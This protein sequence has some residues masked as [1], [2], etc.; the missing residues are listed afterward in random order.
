MGVLFNALCVCVGVVVSSPDSISEEVS[1]Q[2]RR[3]S[4]VPL[5]P[6]GWSQEDTREPTGNTHTI[7]CYKTLKFCYSFKFGPPLFWVKSYFMLQVTNNAVF[8]F[9]SL[10]DP[11]NYHEFCRL[12]ARL[13]SNYQ[14]GELVKVENYPEVIRLIANF[15]VT[16]LQ[17]LYVCVG[18]YALVMELVGWDGMLDAR[19]NVLLKPFSSLLVYQKKIVIVVC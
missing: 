11:N 3:A 2:Q 14:L 16:S 7:T 17:V 19:V 15:T 10:S 13:K 18:S 1:V 8:V 4:Q 6:G 5:S 12:L 9:Q